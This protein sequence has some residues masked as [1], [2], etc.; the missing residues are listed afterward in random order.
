MRPGSSSHRYFGGW[1]PLLRLEPGGSPLPKPPRVGRGSAAP[2]A[3][4]AGQLNKQ[5]FSFPG[6]IG[7]GRVLPATRGGRFGE[8]PCLGFPVCKNEVGGGGCP[9]LGAISGEM[10]VKWRGGNMAQNHPRKGFAAADPDGEGKGGIFL[11]P[12]ESLAPGGGSGGVKAPTAGGGWPQRQ[13]NG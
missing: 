5:P 3:F 1:L 4:P 11:L 8:A 7:V 12:P 10:G 6:F 2:A 13:E 9:K